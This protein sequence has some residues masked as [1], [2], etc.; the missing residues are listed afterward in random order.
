MAGVAPLFPLQRFV[1][2]HAVTMTC[3][4]PSEITLTSFGAALCVSVKKDSIY[5]QNRDCW[6][7]LLLHLPVVNCGAIVEITIAA[8]HCVQFYSASSSDWCALRWFFT[9]FYCF[10]LQFQMDAPW[11][12]HLAVH[13]LFLFTFSLKDMGHKSKLSDMYSNTFFF[14]C[15]PLLAACSSAVLFSAVRPRTWGPV[16]GS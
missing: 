16:L 8:I 3:R 12:V 6:Q 5:Q 13:F 7:L 14:L 9:I 4:F 10:K 11:N 2:C 1:W 15:T